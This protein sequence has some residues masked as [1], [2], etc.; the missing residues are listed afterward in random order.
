VSVP[1]RLSYARSRGLIAAA[2][3]LTVTAA[4][5]SGGGAQWQPAG[6][7]SGAGGAGGAAAT[8]PTRAPGEFTIAPAATATDVAVL[9]PVTV[10]AKDASLQTVTVA[11]P[12]G[13]QVAGEWD[14][15][16]TSWHTSAPLEYGKQYTVTATGTD[17]ARQPLTRTST[18]T[19]MKPQ[20][21]AL[22]YL[23]ANGGLLLKDRSTFGVGQPIVVWFDRRIPDKAAA[24]RLLEVTTTPQV[25]G[26][27]RW[28]SAQ[29]V[30]YRPAEYWRPGTAIT[31]KAKVFG[32]DLG[33]GT[34]GQSNVS[35][36]FKIGPSRI[37]IADA[38][39]KRMQVFLDGQMIRDIPV[40]L[41]KGGTT[42]TSRGQKIN[43]W[44]NSGPHVVLA[45][46]PTTHMT[47]SSYGVTD[48]KHPDFYEKTVKLTVRISNSG[49]FLHLADWNVPAHGRT[50]TSHGCINIG[51][52][53]AQWVYDNFVPGDVVDVKNTPVKLA[54][55]NGLGDWTMSWEEWKKGS[56]L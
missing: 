39:T 17:S 32:K 27:W 25:E 46:T 43:Y 9:D 31:V 8:S 52:A 35:A 24:Q 49:E 1:S 44:T 29:E 2:L 3:A 26:A 38:N 18:F 51:P 5:T 12:D 53:H 45:K 4:C 10:T 21:L 20:A 50:N 11:G 55:T 47:S 22:P 40:S 28:I 15:G 30:H 42:T 37:A 34:Y 7:A 56:A 41:G 36:S 19:T 13:K 14:A 23:R 48:P 33:G 54:L 6:A 16:R